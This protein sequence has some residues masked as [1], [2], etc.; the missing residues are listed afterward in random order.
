MFREREGTG[1]SVCVRAA[2]GLVEL[3]PRIGVLDRCCSL[4]S[5]GAQ[6]V[7]PGDVVGQCSQGELIFHVV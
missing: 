6:Y 5:G 3:R 4:C 2:L 7:Q 1:F